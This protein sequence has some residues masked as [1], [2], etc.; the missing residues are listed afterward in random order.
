[1]GSTYEKILARAKKRLEEETKASAAQKSAEEKNEKE[2]HEQEYSAVHQKI[3]DRI[4]NRNPETGVY[5]PPK[6]RT[7]SESAQSSPSRGETWRALGKSTASGKEETPTPENVIVPQNYTRNLPISSPAQSFIANRAREQEEEKIGTLAMAIRA[8]VNDVPSTQKTQFDLPT[9]SAPKTALELEIQR[10]AGQ[11]G[12][13]TTPATDEEIRLAQKYNVSVDDIRSA[14]K[15]LEDKQTSE[16]NVQTVLPGITRPFTA[17][18]TQRMGAKK[19]TGGLKEVSDTLSYTAASVGLGAADTLKNTTNGIRT[20]VG[21]IATRG[22]YSDGYKK[23]EDYLSGSGISGF[24]KN[25]IYTTDKNGKKMVAADWKERLSRALYERTGVPTKIAS[26]YIDTVETEEMLKLLGENVNDKY[27]DS[28]G[29]GAYTIG[30]QIPGVLL[31]MGYSAAGKTAEE[32]AKTL[33]DKISK[34]VSTSLIAGSV[35]GS[36]VN[37]LARENGYNP[38]NYLNA[39]LQATTEAAL[40]SAIG[41]SDAASFKKLITPTGSAKKTVLKG[42]L[43]YLATGAEE[44]LEEVINVPTSEIIDRMT[45]VSENTKW[46]GDGGVF[47]F[48]EMLK[49]GLSGAAVGDRKSVV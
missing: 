40:E 27:K 12:I 25:V 34:S 9:A 29:A 23:I 33:A 18:E 30:Q 21:D 1:M 41:F 31:T 19:T 22:A 7:K 36:T 8:G 45:G 32:A 49:N 5:E 42:V 16:Q 46:I 48:K 47:D 15:T 43:S 13:T 11:N 24:A 14:K 26:A 10:Q 17:E 4:A 2:T 37:Q 35:Y 38:A 44:G 3:L 20:T 28:V 39:T 6:D